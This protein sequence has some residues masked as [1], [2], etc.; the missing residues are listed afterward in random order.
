MFVG[1]IILLL[2]SI[3]IPDDMI[4]DV[5]SALI[6]EF[7]TNEEFEKTFVLEPDNDIL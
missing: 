6:R 3:W 1:I 2:L 4:D 7:V 5:D